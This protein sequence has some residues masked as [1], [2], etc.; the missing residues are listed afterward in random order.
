MVCKEVLYIIPLIGT[1]ERDSIQER[2][3]QNK[4]M[5]SD[6]DMSRN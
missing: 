4:A 5:I 6:S 2:R 1:R 3:R